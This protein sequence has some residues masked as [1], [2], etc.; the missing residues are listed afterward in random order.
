MYN[1][2]QFRCLKMDGLKQINYRYFIL[3]VRFSVLENV[4]KT[5]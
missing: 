4:T 5:F 2:S 3:D 1:I